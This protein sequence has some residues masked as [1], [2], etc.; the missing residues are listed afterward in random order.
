MMFKLLEL[1]AGI[2]SQR[3]GL[4][5]IGANY[6][7]IGISEI[8]KF[9]LKSY[10]LLYGDFVNF[11]DICNIDPR[12]LPDFNL[13]TYS[14]PCQDISIAGKQRGLDEGT[15]TRSSLLWEC[16]KIIETCLPQYLLMENV[17]NLVGNRHIENF[18]KWLEYLESLGYTNYWKV[19]DAVDY[20]AP[21]TRKRVFCVSIFN[22]EEFVWPSPLPRTKKIKDIL[23]DRVPDEMWID[24]DMI[25]VNNPRESDNGLILVGNLNASNRFDSA[26]RVYSIEGVAPTLN[27]TSADRP[28]V[29]INGRV[30]HLTARECWALMGFGNEAFDKVKGKVSSTQLYKQAGNSI[31]VP[32]LEAIFKQMEKI[33]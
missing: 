13:M 26:R 4:D 18:N 21:Q 15:G 28:K 29:L 31:C 2:G 3:T 10:G 1:F 12:D 23:E 11:G 17:K 5:N 14:F 19:L 33:C 22:S 8:D 24:I 9:A 7:V 6:E 20:G 25:P 16:M 32:C 27:T 30:R